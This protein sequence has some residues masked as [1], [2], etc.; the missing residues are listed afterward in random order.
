MFF[1]DDH[2]RYC[3]IYLMKHRSEFFD[4][5]KTFHALVKT[6]H[7]VVIKCFKCDMGREYTSNKFYELLSLDGTI[8]QTSCIDTLNKMVSLRENINK[9][10]RLLTLSC[11]LLQFLVS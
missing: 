7:C 11:Y 10:L 4:V 2:I 8:H 9:L 1:I 5:Y 3:R 6:Q